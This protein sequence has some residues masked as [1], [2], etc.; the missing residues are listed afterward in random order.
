MFCDFSL[1]LTLSLLTPLQAFVDLSSFPPD[2]VAVVVVHNI[3]QLFLTGKSLNLI[4]S[5]V[6][7][8][9]DLNGDSVDGRTGWLCLHL[10]QPHRQ[11]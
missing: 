4:D 11:D 7:L 6:F 2:V 5:V 10:P 1:S 3:S 9:Q 8:S